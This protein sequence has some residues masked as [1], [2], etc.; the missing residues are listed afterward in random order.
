MTTPV[1]CASL[2]RPGFESTAMVA[3]S[4]RQRRRESELIVNHRLSSVLWSRLSTFT[5]ASEHVSSQSQQHRR[6]IRTAALIVD[7][8]DV[9]HDRFPNDQIVAFHW[10]AMSLRAPVPHFLREATL[11]CQTPLSNVSA[12]YR[13]TCLTHTH[14]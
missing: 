6:W 4:A 2:G 14:P 12:V 9:E 11:R 13:P 5:A 10:I 7:G 8:S 3:F 1:R